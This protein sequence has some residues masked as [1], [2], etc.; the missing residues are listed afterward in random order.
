ASYTH[1]LHDALP[2]WVMSTLPTCGSLAPSWSLCGPKTPTG[3]TPKSQSA[4]AAPTWATTLAG[5]RSSSIFS[6]RS[7]VND[8]GCAAG[9][10]DRSEEHTSELQSREK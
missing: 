6:P 8:Q 3:R 4:A 5:V 10:D 2:I 7:S 1:S 9:A